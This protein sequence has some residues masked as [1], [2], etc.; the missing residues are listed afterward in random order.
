TSLAGLLAANL[1]IGLLG[2]GVLLT[3][4]TWDRLR[5]ASRVGPSLLAG[6]AAAATLLPPLI[7]AG[8]EP[9]LLVIG[10]LAV[11]AIAL[12]VALRRRRR[13]GGAGA[14]GAGRGA[15]AARG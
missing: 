7:Y 12:G 14:G 5:P 2:A 6:F 8:F 4:G 11:L 9:T 10:A 1:A 3:T 15:P 13:P